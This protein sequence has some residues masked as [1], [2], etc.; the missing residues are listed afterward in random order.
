MNWLL[1]GLLGVG[2]LVAWSRARS[3]WRRRQFRRYFPVMRRL[4]AE[5]SYREALDLQQRTPGLSWRYKLSPAQAVEVADLETEALVGVGRTSDAVVQLGHH[6]SARFNAGEW[7]SDRLE[8]WLA[9]YRQAGPLPVEAFYFCEVC[10][11]A[12]DME[13]LLRHAI[14]SGCEPPTGF[15]GTHGSSGVVHL[16][17][18]RKF[19]D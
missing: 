18:P 5:H 6:L 19:G 16:T 17:P 14:D 10:G 4:V 11:L 13:C 12:P 1:Y 15:P 2:A 3:A 9:L 7:P 8:R